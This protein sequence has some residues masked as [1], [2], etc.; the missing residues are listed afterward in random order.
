MESE[1]LSSA[2]MV[3]TW[4][5][6]VSRGGRMVP[7]GASW[8]AERERLERQSP[9]YRASRSPS[10]LRTSCPGR[11]RGSKMG[12]GSPPYPA[13]WLEGNDPVVLI[14]DIRGRK[15]AAGANALNCFLGWW[16]RYGRYSRVPPQAADAEG[17]GHHNIFD[18][19]TAEDNMLSNMLGSNSTAPANGVL[20]VNVQ[21]RLRYSCRLGSA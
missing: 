13:F 5:I 11:S 3:Y 10:A 1:Q 19:R 15:E 12:G 6:V 2:R 20:G 7:V 4:Y 17:K 8:E 21:G 16:D 18:R 14:A 9:L